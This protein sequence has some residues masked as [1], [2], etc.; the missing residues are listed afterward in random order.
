[1]TVHQFHH[2]H[3]PMSEYRA[4][5]VTDILGVAH[6]LKNTRQTNCEES[7]YAKRSETVPYG[8]NV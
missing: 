1:V 3:R 2:V 5:H 8:I 7:P 4:S 6:V